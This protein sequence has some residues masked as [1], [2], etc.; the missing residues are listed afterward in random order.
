VVGLN[1][2]TFA[3]RAGHYYAR[4]SNRFWRLLHRSGFTER[5]LSCEE[6]G[7][8]PSYG[9]AVTDLVKR[10]SPNVD[11]VGVAEF[12][13]SRARLLRLVETLQPAVVAFNGLTGYRAAFDRRAAIGLQPEP[14]AGAKVMLLPSSSARAGATYSFEVLLAHWVAL[15]AL[16]RAEVTSAG[17]WAARSPR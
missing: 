12:R 7:A 17:A 8:L 9:I 2:A 4:R 3:V 16:V 5:E 10:H 13:R 14:I 15:H 6:D 1:P 11:D